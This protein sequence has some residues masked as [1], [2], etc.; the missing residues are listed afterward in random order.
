MKELQILNSKVGKDVNVYEQGRLSM[1]IEDMDK[2]LTRLREL[3]LKEEDNLL[4]DHHLYDFEGGKISFSDTISFQSPRKKQKSTY[5]DIIPGG[6]M[7]NNN[8]AAQVNGTPVNG[9]SLNGK[10]VNGSH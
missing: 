1:S 9:T 5:H 7:L 2:K 10:H 3:L 4:I 6:L 8:V